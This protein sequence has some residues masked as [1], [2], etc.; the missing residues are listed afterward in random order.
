[1]SGFP[2]IG[3][4]SKGSSN[5]QSIRFPDIFSPSEELVYPY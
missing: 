5:C 1:M 2:Q 3:Q 4:I